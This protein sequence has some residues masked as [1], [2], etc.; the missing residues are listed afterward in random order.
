MLGQI[1]WVKYLAAFFN[2]EAEAHFIYD[3]AH[4]VYYHYKNLMDER[5]PH[6]PTP[7]PT[8][9]ITA[10]SPGGD[11]Y[12]PFIVIDPYMVSAIEA[13]GGHMANRSDVMYLGLNQT[14]WGIYFPLPTNTTDSDYHIRTQ[15]AY[16]S[17]HTILQHVDVLI[18]YMAVGGTS[19]DS[20]FHMYN[21][22][23]SDMTYPFIANQRVYAV[24]KRVSSGK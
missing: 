18:D 12:G 10:F 20:V 2:K 14:E 22:S 3:V 24:D 15:A 9:A 11:Y 19:L 6:P 17:F 7:R 16:T 23:K 1:E 4:Y 21:I 13:V 5:Y 8:V